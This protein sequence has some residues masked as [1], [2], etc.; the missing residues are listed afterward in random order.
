MVLLVAVYTWS[1]QI[2]LTI[3]KDAP[4]DAKDV[5]AVG[6]RWMWKFQHYP[7]GQS[8]ID[9]LHVVVGEPVKLTMTS[10]DVIHSLVHSRFSG[11]EKCHP[12][13]LHHYVV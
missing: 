5:T 9:E 10:Q 8:E 13:A 12:W 1:E 7:D 2:Y 6:K 4:R 11:T 3:A